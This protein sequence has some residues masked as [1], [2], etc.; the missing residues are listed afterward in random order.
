M[1]AD[2]RSWELLVE[3]LLVAYAQI[4]KD[5][6]ARLPPKTTSLRDWGQR[7]SEWAKSEELFAQLPYWKRQS[8]G[9]SLPRDHVREPSPHV[10]NDTIPVGLELD[11]VGPHLHNETSLAPIRFRR[12]MI[13]AAALALAEW[14]G[15]ES[16]TLDVE[17]DGR[18]SVFGDVDLSRTVG[19]L[20]SVFPVKLNKLDGSPE[21]IMSNVD[22]HLRGMPYAG[23]GYGVLRHLSR[24]DE[25]RSALRRDAAQVLIKSPGEAGFG[26]QVS[27]PTADETPRA[28]RSASEDYL[29]EVRGQVVD[30]LFIFEFKFN[31]AIHLERTIVALAN[32]FARHIRVLI[33]HESEQT[34]TPK[35]ADFPLAKL[36]D[37]TLDRVISMA[38]KRPR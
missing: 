21:E 12:L 22:Q 36:D 6:P 31:P 30:Q 19:R 9:F 5:Q 23:L 33:Q 24:D 34:A 1:V 35:A 3:D 7:L 8:S 20:T 17:D 10:A 14:T 38:N 16:V 15:Q 27:S 25:V 28:T 18:T 26:V 37:E 32:D 4:E 2:P 11:E 29:I 13:G